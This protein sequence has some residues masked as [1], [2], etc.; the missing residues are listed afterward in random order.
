[1]RTLLTALVRATNVFSHHRDDQMVELGIR[2]PEL[3]VMRAVELNPDASTAEVRRTLGMHHA[4]FSD[5][6]R[7]CIYRGYVIQEPFP[8]DRRTR[9]LRLTVPGWVAFRIGS[10]LQLDLEASAGTGPWMAETLDRVY[11]VGHRLMAVPP[12]DRY[13]DGAPV[14]T[15]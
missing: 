2:T 8:R 6:V 12:A 9:R 10:A 11:L 14:A 4:A 5:L 13:P 15:A 7:R 1:M 3:L